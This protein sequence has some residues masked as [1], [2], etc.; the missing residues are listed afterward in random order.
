MKRIG[1]I[2][3]SDPVDKSK[4]NEII[5]RL[6][7]SGYQIIVANSL[8]KSASAKEKADDFNMFCKL[9]LEGIFDLS[10]GDLA[11]TCIPFI[12]FKAYQNCSACFY[13]YSDLSV[14]LNALYSKTKKKTCLFQLR[15]NLNIEDTQN[16]FKF[17]WLK[18]KNMKGIVIG[19]NIRCFLKLAGTSYFPE[20]ED[21]ILFLE[22]H[23]G[24]INK[25]ITYLTQL[26]MMGVF[27]K[28]N[29]LILG[30][31]TE[32]DKTSTDHLLE[33]YVSKYP[34]GIIRTHEVGHS[35]NSKAV[36]IGKEYCF[37][38]KGA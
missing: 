13:G 29:G 8:F 36:W 34:I 3:L 26:E 4:V 25:I 20:T 35:L 6:E 15:N 31:F 23:S 10:G 24:N 33:S 7:K 2:G 9:D 17:T 11:N 5:T 30:Q 1:L 37:K 16:A 18:K 27:N 38:S 22:S 14:V 28:I 12:D 21:K 32:L 19:G